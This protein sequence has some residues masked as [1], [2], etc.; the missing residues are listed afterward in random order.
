MATAWQD[1]VVA[2][3]DAESPID[4]DFMDKVHGNQQSL[5]TQQIEDTF[6]NIIAT[7]SGDATGSYVSKLSRSE[8][9]FPPAVATTDPIAY[10]VRLRVKIDS[11]ATGQIRASIGSTWA[12]SSVFSNTAYAYI[13]I[14]MDVTELR[15]AAGSF[16]TLL[17]ELKRVTGTT[18]QQVYCDGSDHGSRIEG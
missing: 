9:Y 12:E 14:V 11:G 18:G 8:V 16:E 2:D 15:A 6:S 1:I 17:I 3:K 7:N 4:V 13:E 5:I 10:I